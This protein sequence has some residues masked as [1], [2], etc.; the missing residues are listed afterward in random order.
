MLIAY[1]PNSVT[2]KTDAAIQ[3]VDADGNVTFQ[4]DSSA[5][6]DETVGGAN[7]DYAHINSVEIVD[8]GTNFLASF[9]H[10]SAAI[11]IARVAHDGFA[12]GDIVWKLGGRDSSFDFVD[13]P[14]DGP[15]AQHTA[16]QI[17]SWDGQ[18][19][20]YVMVF[21]D[22][23]VTGFGNLCVDQADPD[24]DPIERGQSRAVIYRLDEV[25]HTATLVWSY[26][27][28]T[29]FT[30][31]MGSSQ[32]LPA[33]GNVMIGWAAETAR[34]RQRGRAR[35]HPGVA[36]DSGTELLRPG[37]THLHLLPRAQVRRP[38][39]DASLGQGGLAG[40]RCGL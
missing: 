39:R 16:T 28:P 24:G 38:R 29:W 9:R 37:P 18:P 8:G 12:E 22:G 31:F 4:W 21:D 10:F 26:G 36:A 3:E 32:F 33:T 40:G 35:R 23:S 30:F 6:A 11:K 17:S 5:I 15:C 13:D 14:Y 2:G 34:A 7:P 19:G 25:A 27:P 20:E 1:Q